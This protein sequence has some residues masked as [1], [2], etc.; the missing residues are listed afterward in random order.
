MVFA[1]S[2]LAGCDSGVRSQYVRAVRQSFI[3]IRRDHQT[4][5]TFMYYF[6]LQ[7]LNVL[8]PTD[9]AEMAIDVQLALQ[10]LRYIVNVAFFPFPAFRCV[11]VS[12]QS[13]SSFSQAMV[14]VLGAMGHRCQCSHRLCQESVPVP[15]VLA[16]ERNW[17][18]ARS[19]CVHLVELLGARDQAGRGRRNGTSERLAA[20]VLSG[21]LCWLVAVKLGVLTY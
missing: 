16:A 13:A 21:A 3:P 2:G 5:W 1:L 6:I 7:S 17:L 9:Q 19:A 4:M 18:P 14:P 11:F 15:R 10:N 12:S 20:P 8:T